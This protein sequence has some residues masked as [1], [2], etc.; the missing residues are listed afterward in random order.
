MKM[1]MKNRS[2]RYDINRPSSR[3]GHKYSK[4]KKCPTK[5]MIICINQHLSD[6]WSSIQ[7]KV[8]QQWGWAEKKHCL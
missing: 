6:I 1:K 4:Y 8:K 2:D 3:R 7:E 5:M